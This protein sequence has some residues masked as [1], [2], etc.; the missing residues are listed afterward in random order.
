M[1]FCGVQPTSLISKCGCR[2][3]KYCQALFREIKLTTYVMG[4]RYGEKAEI[5]IGK[6]SFNSIGYQ[7]HALKA[8]FLAIY[9]VW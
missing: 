7:S 5:P 2:T 4:E 8:P 6:N 3:W 9:G 1:A